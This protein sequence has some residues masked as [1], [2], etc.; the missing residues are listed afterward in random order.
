MFRQKNLKSIYPAILN[1]NTEGCLLGID[2]SM[3]LRHRL[4]V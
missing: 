1:Y 2:S 3:A 4:G